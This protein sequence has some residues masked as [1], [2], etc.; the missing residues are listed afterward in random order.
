[1]TWRLTSWQRAWSRCGSASCREG[2]WA[3]SQLRNPQQGPQM[4]MALTWRGLSHCAG[5]AAAPQLPQC[6]VWKPA[7]S[8]ACFWQSR[9]IS[10]LNERKKV[11]KKEE[12]GHRG[13]AGPKMGEMMSLGVHVYAM[14]NSKTSCR[15]DLVRWWIHARSFHQS[16]EVLF[17]GTTDG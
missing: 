11:V 13:R 6:P 9:I 5:L 17:G 15:Q 7:R 8:P 12:G 2:T 1:M 14:D 3:V 10:G 4:R 16:S